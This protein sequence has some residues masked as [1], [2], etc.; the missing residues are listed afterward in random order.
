MPMV[1]TQ[2]IEVVLTVLFLRLLNFAILD[3]FAPLFSLV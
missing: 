2:A 3:D 1:D